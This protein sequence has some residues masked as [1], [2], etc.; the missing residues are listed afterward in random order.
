MISHGNFAFYLFPRLQNDVLFNGSRSMDSTGY[1]PSRN[2]NLQHRFPRNRH[3]QMHDQ[4]YNVSYLR[5]NICAEFVVFK[6]REG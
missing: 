1:H 6:L 3:S 4:N 2:E 5:V